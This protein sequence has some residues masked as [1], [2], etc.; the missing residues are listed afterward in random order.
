MEHSDRT[1]RKYRGTKCLNCELP[2]EKSDGY[3]PNCG[4]INSTKKLTLLDMLEEFMSSI[5]SYD[6][7]LHKTL[8]ALILK[9]GKITTEFVSGKRAKYT[10]PFRFFFSVT[11]LYF[12][13]IS[14]S[15]N[16][17]NLEDSINSA[18]SMRDS[19]FIESALMEVKANNLDKKDAAII[20]SMIAK[21]NPKREIELHELPQEYFKKLDQNNLIAQRLYDK[22]EFFYEDLQR[23]KYKTYPEAIVSLNI[24]KSLE[25]HMTFNIAKS[26]HKTYNDPGRFFTTLI[27]KLPF[28]IF[29][30]IPFFTI[31]I[32]LVYSSK[33]YHYIDHLIFSFHTQTLFTILLIT[34]LIIKWIFN[35]DL[36]GITLIIFFFYLYKAMRG[37]YKEGRLKTIVKFVYL[38]TIFLILATVSTSLVILIGAFTF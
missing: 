4:Q 31:F 14:Y 19:I 1:S 24:P 12:L 7:K 16:F 18:V 37:F 2:L 25:N 26:A 29:F 33:K 27:S 9:P 22:T 23:K 5:L 34:T 11:L 38:N 21:Y 10:N 32:W 13:M 6:S 15:S 3:C 17:D 30:Y 8:A 36:H 20:D 35:I 28:I